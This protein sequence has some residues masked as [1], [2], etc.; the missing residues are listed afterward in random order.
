MLPIVL[1]SG[2]AYR[3][4]VLR[5]LRVDFQVCSSHIDETPLPGES[6]ENLVQ[7]LSLSK[8]QA[9]STRYPN[10]LIIGSDQLAVCGGQ[11]LNKPGDKP[12]AIQQLK[13]QAGRA[14]KFYTGI[15][16]L[17]SASRHYLDDIDICTTHFKALSDSQIERYL[18]LEQPYDCAGSFKSEGLGIAL[19]SKITGDDP[20]ALIGLPLIKLIDLLKQF[21]V[22][23][24]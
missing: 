23:V 21:S 12:R 1:A 7:R 13:T 5:K 10:H 14:V 22:E 19:F 18:D 4:E 20:N 8:A 16:V 3:A 2:S 6:A 9:I 15:C 11:F 24:I 17:N